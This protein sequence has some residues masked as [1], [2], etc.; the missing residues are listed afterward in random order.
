MCKKKKKGQ[1]HEKTK[2][3]AWHDGL[4]EPSD[5]LMHNCQRAKTFK[6]S[7]TQSKKNLA[8][9]A[10]YHNHDDLCEPYH[11][12]N[13]QL[14]TCKNVHSEICTVRKISTLIKIYYNRIVHPKAAR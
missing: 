5:H 6:E 11:Y 14:S 10:I 7:D 9:I 2:L 4:F 3:S 13:A 1:N 12:F 8:L